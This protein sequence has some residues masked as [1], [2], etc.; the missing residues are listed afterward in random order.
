VSQAWSQRWRD[1]FDDANPQV[2]RRVSRGRAYERS[3][4][5]SDVRTRPGVL[6]GRVQGSRATPY[7]VEVEV[8]AFDDGTWDRIVAALATELRSS[9]QLLAG[10][11]PAALE[12]PGVR[13]F[14]VAAELATAC[15]C[16][17][18]V[19]PCSH[20]AALWEAVAQRLDDEPFLL[21]RLR[22]RGRARLLAELAAAR[23]G[24][25]RESPQAGVVALDRLPSGAAWTRG[26]GLDDV[27]LPVLDAPTS[28]APALRLLGDPPGWAGA[29]SAWELL[30]PL[31]QRAASWADAEHDAR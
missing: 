15:G 20:A 6:S 28:P 8:P 12:V 7:L 30:H 13:L 4:R 16:G 2:S 27:E 10:Q 17:D 24:G 3:G 5:V 19:S 18:A 26:R 11:A 14:P 1:A 9:A 31:V 23:R 29:L 25:A 22:G 21:L